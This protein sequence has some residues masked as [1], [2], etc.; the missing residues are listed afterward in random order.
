METEGSL[1]HS[2]LPATC[3]YPEPDQSRPCPKNQRPEDPSYHPPIY[4]WIFQVVSFS[5]VSRR[6]TSVHLSSSHTCYMPRP[7]HSSRFYHPNNI[8]WRVQIIKFLNCDFL[9]SPVPCLSYAKIFSSAPYSK[10]TTGYVSPS[11]WVTKFHT[12]TQLQAQFFLY[13]LIFIW[14]ANWKIKYFAPNENKHSLTSFCSW[15]L[16]E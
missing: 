2:Q 14:V 15:F 3:H 7:S 8:W 16:P 12:H 9:H 1:P 13:I 10:T 6:K 11:M 5:Q 4:A